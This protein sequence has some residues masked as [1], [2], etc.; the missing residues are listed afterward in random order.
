MRMN[1]QPEGRKMKQS[2]QFVNRKIG[3]KIY[4]L[5]IGQKAAGM[6]KG[7]S[8]NETGAFLWDALKEN[9]SEEKLI[10]ISKEHFGISED[11]IG[12]LEKDVSAFLKA[13]RDRGMLEGTKSIF[14]CSCSYCSDTVPM[15]RKSCF[16]NQDGTIAEEINGIRHHIDIEMG[17]IGV[18]LYGDESYF[19]NDFDHFK[20]GKLPE[21]SMRIEVVPEEPEEMSEGYYDE[22]GSK[23]S[24]DA[25]DKADGLTEENGNV[26]IHQQDLTVLEFS[27]KYVL[28]FPKAT[29]IY[30]VHIK[31]DGSLARIYCEPGNEVKKQDIFWVIR[32]LFLVF[33]LNNGLVMVHSA[34]ILF[35][36]KAWLFS[37]ASGSGK[38]TQ[39]QLWKNVFDV[40]VINGDLNLVGMKDGIPVIYGTPWCGSSGVFDNKI[41]PLG[42]IILLRR[43][44]NTIQELTYDQKV[45]YVQQRIIS[46]TWTE[47][48]FDRGLKVVEDIVPGIYVKRYYCNKE[49]ESAVCIHDDIESS[50]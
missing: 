9:I 11:G 37:G 14:G 38:S 34:S 15:D 35:K 48:M 49:D 50:L 21:N 12:M 16:D 28:F 6:V 26:L 36:G 47:D 41:Y 17:D 13:L 24:A 3:D 40:P 2:D 4:I 1:K 5:P 25:E 19:V 27:G 43:G 33:A 29:R 32:I 20:T 7:L 18:S 22:E 23:D 8:L 44:N 39:S 42:G 30:E 46:P 10:S 31:K 45:L